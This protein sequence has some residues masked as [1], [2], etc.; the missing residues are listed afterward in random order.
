MLCVQLYGRSAQVLTFAQNLSKRTAIH[1]P[2][3]SHKCPNLESIALGRCR[4][5]RGEATGGR[6]CAVDAWD[7][8][9]MECT[10]RDVLGSEAAIMSSHDRGSTVEMSGRGKYRSLCAAHDATCGSNCESPLYSSVS[11]SYTHLTL[12]TICS[13]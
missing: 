6:R 10:A 7:D 4:W 9:H 3:S 1:D 12:P 5:R 2:K 11:V 8:R 13:V